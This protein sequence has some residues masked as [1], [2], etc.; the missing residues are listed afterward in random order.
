VSVKATASIDR[1]ALTQP[2]YG[3]AAKTPTQRR[4]GAEAPPR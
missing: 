1:Q 4:G 2:Q 3:N